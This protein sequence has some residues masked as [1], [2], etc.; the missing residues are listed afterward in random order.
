VA[1]PVAVRYGWADNPDCNMVND[2]GLPAFAVSYRQLVRD[3]CT[4]VANKR[5]CV[6]ATKA[7]GFRA[8]QTRGVRCSSPC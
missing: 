2:A 3:R 6:R 7:A 4:E 5:G 1:K 8:R